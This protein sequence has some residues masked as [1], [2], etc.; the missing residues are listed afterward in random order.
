MSGL[1]RQFSLMRQ[2][3]HTV[4]AAHN[5]TAIKR[6]RE[7]GEVVMCWVLHYSWRDILGPKRED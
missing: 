7:W 4:H 5:I 1:A 2:T 3:R 6:N